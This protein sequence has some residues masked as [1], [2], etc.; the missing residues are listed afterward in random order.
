[1]NVVGQTVSIYKT[2]LTHSCV[3]K[4]SPQIKPVW[5]INVV[6]QTVSIYKTS[7]FHSCCW[8]NCLHLW[9][10][11]DDDV[12]KLDVVYIICNGDGSDVKSKTS[13]VAD[14]NADWSSFIIR[15]CKGAIL[16]K[17]SARLWILHYNII[18]RK[19]VTFKRFIHI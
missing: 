9:S 1:M 4:L 11:R 18:T 19:K 15:G 17:S 2:S 14:V 16:N 10:S 3:A 8:P 6:G 12:E 7:L 13:A 5:F